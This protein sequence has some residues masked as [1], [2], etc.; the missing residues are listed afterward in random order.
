M[1]VPAALAAATGNLAIP[2]NDG[3]AYSLIAARFARTGT[4][5][6][7]GWNNPFS[8]GQE[9]LLGPLGRSIVAQQLLVV[10]LAAAALVA[11][12][13]LF[14]TTMSPR[15]ALFGTAV[16]AAFP[17][18]GLLATS[19]M[20]DIPTYLAIVVT[21]LVGR[22]A[23]KRRSFAGAVVSVAAGVW[24]FATREQAIAAVVAVLVSALVAWTDR[25]MR[26]KLVALAA[27]TLATVL[28]LEAW[29][30]S[31]ANGQAPV[32]A[33]SVRGGAIV[34]VDAFFT[35]GLVVFP[36][37]VATSRPSTWIPPARVAFGLTALVGA[38]FLAS[39][40]TLLL[41]NYL[42]WSGPYSTVLIG[43][44]RVLPK[45]A[46]DVLQ[47]A[48]WIGGALSAGAMLDRVHRLDATLALFGLLTV[49]GTGF[50]ALLGQGIFDRML[51]PL[52]PVALVM[53]LG[54][55]SRNRVPRWRLIAAGGSL[56]ALFAVSLLIT[57]NGLAFDAARW[58]AAE[59]LVKRGVS[60]QAIDAGLE[61]TGYHY[62]G[63][64]VDARPSKQRARLPWYAQTLFPRAPECYVMASSP[65][66][67][68]GRITMLF[69]YRTYLAFGRS[70]LL[71][72]STGRCHDS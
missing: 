17:G 18:F 60:P 23:I 67:G 26:T 70:R 29:R 52:V 34:C 20:E 63:P 35:L 7:V 13:F 58:S 9:V 14:R 56:A 32:V 37:V 43:T 59:S 30:R 12:S 16:V 19:F 57:A 1:A 48:A 53:I 72:Y 54:V 49:L 36:A 69:D 5:T 3:W 15:R 61:W 66:A 71:L 28:A 64:A 68:L 31:L 38:A 27:V 25:P 11:T 39:H 2:H 62:P 6:L 21:L 55:S 10:V 41:G 42:S 40:H 50:G 8:V 22:I 45:V 33:L 51:V 44:R 46:W 47:L 4:I 65:V 24:G